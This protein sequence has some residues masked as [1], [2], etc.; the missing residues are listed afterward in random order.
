M[1]LWCLLWPAQS[2]AW[3]C[4]VQ[5]LHQSLLRI[6]WGQQQRVPSSWAGVRQRNVVKMSECGQEIN[7]QRMKTC[8]HHPPHQLTILTTDHLSALLPIPHQCQQIKHS[9]PHSSSPRAEKTNNSGQRLHVLIIS[10]L[11]RVATGG[12]RC[13]DHWSV[14]T[15]YSWWWRATGIIMTRFIRAYWE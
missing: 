1:R 8:N 9:V 6:P 10:S 14:V 4:H 13:V 12:V 15:C 7:Q 5:S 11:V 3:L 2:S